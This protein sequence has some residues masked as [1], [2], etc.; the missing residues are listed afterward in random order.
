LLD[1][2]EL[3]ETMKAEPG[4]T[5]EA[6]GQ[7]PI[8][9]ELDLT[10]T[11]RKQPPNEELLY[12]VRRRAMRLRALGAPGL[13][14]ILELDRDRSVAHI[15]LHNGSGPCISEHDHDAF[16]AVRNAFDRLGC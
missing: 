8:Q 2:P 14:V 3:E 4:Q 11:F 9:S 15:H 12:F 13:D 7:D 6:S 16:I 1:G 5:R 10:V